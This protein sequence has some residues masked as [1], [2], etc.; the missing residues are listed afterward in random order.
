M[1]E[2][3]KN[4]MFLE[5]SGEKKRRLK[6]ISKEKLHLLVFRIMFHKFLYQQKRYIK[7]ETVRKLAKSVIFS[8]VTS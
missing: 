3:Q 5:P 6:N 1:S 7:L 4:G 8:L 2:I